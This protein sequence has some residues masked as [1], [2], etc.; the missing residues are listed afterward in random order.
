MAFYFVDF[1]FNS[2][3]TKYAGRTTNPEGKQFRFGDL[4][5]YLLKIRR[6]KLRANKQQ[7]KLKN[8]P[9]IYWRCDAILCTISGFSVQ[10]KNRK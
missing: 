7:L 9:N 2:D 10:E 4:C 6:E 1:V 5:A 8:K 3:H